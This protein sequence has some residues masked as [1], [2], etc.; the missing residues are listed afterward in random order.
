M[1]D[2]ERGA[3]REAGLSAPLPPPRPQYGEY[4][5]KEEQLSRIQDPEARASLLT[6]P[7][8]ASAP[9][10]APPTTPQGRRRPVDRIV[11]FGL[12]AYGVVSVFLTV[13]QMLDFGTFADQWMEMAG[14]SG[15]FT[16]YEQGTFWG[17][18][19]ALVLV[20]G[21]ALTAWWAVRCLRRGAVS[22]WVPVVGAAATILV[23]SV[24]LLPP[25]LS[26]PA[27]QGFFISPR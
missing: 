6:P 21:F 15:E 18:I 12:L 13:P 24:L 26:D 25:L 7:E 16:N 22:W 2:D 10:A 17:R 4:A 8:A 5:S 1:S 20:A 27:V 19:A 9:P 11:T 23:A 3:S 14:I